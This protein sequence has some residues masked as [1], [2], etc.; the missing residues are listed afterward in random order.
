M[1]LAIGII[2]TLFTAMF[3][4]RL[5]YDAYLSRRHVERLSI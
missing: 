5:I 3:F 2:T 1:T 4:T